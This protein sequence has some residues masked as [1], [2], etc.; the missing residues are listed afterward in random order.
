MF[1]DTQCMGSFPVVSDGSGCGQTV[2]WMAEMEEMYGSAL[3]PDAAYPDVMRCLQGRVER[4]EVW[5]DKDVPAAWSPA[6]NSDFSCKSVLVREAFMASLG[7]VSFSLKR[8]V[9]GLQEDTGFCSI[10]RKLFPG[11]A[12][13]AAAHLAAEFA[14]LRSASVSQ[15]LRESL[16]AGPLRPISLDTEEGFA[17]TWDDRFTI[18]MKFDEPKNLKKI[19]QGTKGKSLKEH[20]AS[21]PKSL[22]QRLYALVKVKI[23]DMDAYCLV[24]SNEAYQLERKVGKARRYDLKGKSRSQSKKSKNPF[25]GKNGDFKEKEANRLLLKN[26][27][28]KSLRG[29]GELKRVCSHRGKTISNDISWLQSQQLA[30]YSLFLEVTQPA[31]GCGELPGTPRCNYH[32]QE[33]A[34]TTLSIVDYLKDRRS[35]SA[36]KFGE[37]MLAFLDEVCVDNKSE[38]MDSWQIYLIVGCFATLLI[39]GAVLGWKYGAAFM[40]SDRPHELRD[41][42]LT[43]PRNPYRPYG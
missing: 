15:E 10:Y 5:P 27:Q 19:L 12:C 40:R 33:S 7:H 41:V 21:N 13:E 23:L 22:L 26:W 42:E 37:Q 9:R 8:S 25:I 29:L 28:C 18:A 39:C 34:A 1:R 11:Q 6:K 14:Q 32:E 30:E 2:P 24:M 3:A 20:L 43:A 35:S 31:M 4:W 17:R 16:Q 36:K 38:S